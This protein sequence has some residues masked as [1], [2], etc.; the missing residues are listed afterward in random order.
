MEFKDMLKYFR[1]RENLTQSELAE[2]LG[3]STSRISMYETG[4]REPDFETEEKIADFF[5]TD[6]NT[7]RGRD[8]EQDVFPHELASKYFAL[9]NEGKL[10]VNNAIETEYDKEQLKIK[11]YKKAMSL[12][13]ITNIDDAKAIVGNSAAFSGYATDEDLISMANIVLQTERKKKK[14]K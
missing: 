4:E 12:D 7:L 8:S 3:V 1:K 2:K 9:S 13:K 14:K 10:T 11:A 5:N 6:L